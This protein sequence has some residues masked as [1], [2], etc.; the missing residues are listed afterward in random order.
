[1]YGSTKLRVPGSIPAA[2][3]LGGSR[4]SGLV[5]AITG[6]LTLTKPGTT[7]RTLTV[8]D[9][10]GTVALLD[11]AHTWTAEQT[12]NGTLTLCAANGGSF[13][14]GVPSRD[15][16]WGLYLKGHSG[17]FADIALVSSGGGT[18][19]RITDAAG[20]G[21][22]VAPTAG[23]GL[24]QLASGTTKANGIAFGDTFLYRNATGLL[25]L[26]YGGTDGTLLLA[27]AFVEIG[28][29]RSVAGVALI[30][31]ISETGAPDYNGRILRNVGAN[32]NLDIVNTG[33]GRVVLA[34]NQSDAVAADASTTGGHTRLLIYD[35]DNGTLERVTVGAA[36]SGGTGYKVLR[37]PN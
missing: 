7:P 30:D 1:M 34:P 35:V 13:A 22:N 8:P 9:A 29:G 33:T 14:A 4:D 18:E 17:A 24:M 21:I 11:L 15:A 36:D 2:D 3:G 16:N 23:N 32:A 25:H 20:V 10:T 31:L 28:A 19:L 6:T 26:N 37:I 5:T 12:F 27:P